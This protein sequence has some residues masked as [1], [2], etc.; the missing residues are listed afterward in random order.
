MFGEVVSGEPSIATR[1]TLNWQAGPQTIG[2]T[3]GCCWA[4]SPHAAV[5][6]PLE[7]AKAS[8]KSVI[9]RTRE[10]KQAVSFCIATELY[11]NIL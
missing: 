6:A 3:P 7:N 8:L 10:R 4:R 5:G 9:C 11:V 1:L 2:V